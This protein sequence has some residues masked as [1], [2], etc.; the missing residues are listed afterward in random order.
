M[1]LMIYSESMSRT[2]S[3]LDFPIS[4]SPEAVKGFKEVFKKE[5]GVDYTNEEAVEGA[6]NL[7]NFFRVLM[8]MDRSLFLARKNVI[9]VLKEILSTNSPK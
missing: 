1:M 8:K 4:P 6:Y 3:I 5:Y 9:D 7:L 2:G